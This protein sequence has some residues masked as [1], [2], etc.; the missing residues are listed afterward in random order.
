ME[1]KKVR[2]WLERLSN[3]WKA[4]E[5]SLHL[6]PKSLSPSSSSSTT[7][8]WRLHSASAFAAIWDNDDLI[9]RLISFI[10]ESQGSTTPN[11]NMIPAITKEEKDETVANTLTQENFERHLAAMAAAAAAAAA[12]G[13]TTGSSRSSSS[14][15][16]KDILF[17]RSKVRVPFQTHFCTKCDNFSLGWWDDRRSNKWR[18]N[19]SQNDLNQQYFQSR[20]DS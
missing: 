20:N 10:M 3:Q 18:P 7:R 1:R 6:T 15:L 17:P 8:P 16:I 11:A 2:A 14:F 9:R 5:E 12:H 4:Q 13:S 19:W